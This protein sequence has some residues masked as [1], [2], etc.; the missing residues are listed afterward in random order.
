MSSFSFAF[1]LQDDQHEPTHTESSAPPPPWWQDYLT[2]QRHTNNNN[3]SSE[4]LLK[5]DPPSSTQSFPHEPFIIHDLQFKKI[6]PSK[7]HRID[8]TSD[9]IPGQYEGGL[10]IWECTI[11]LVDYMRQRQQFLPSI[12][13]SRVIELGCGQGFPGIFALQLGY[14]HVLFSDF[15]KEVIEDITWPNILLNF[16]TAISRGVECFS[17][18]WIDLH[19]LLLAERLAPN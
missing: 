11:D 5:I 13:T 17:G 18:D 16:D 3:N 10:K 8:E 7:K 9:L 15:N 2:D 12:S 14:T 19:H 6:K 4:P 1:H